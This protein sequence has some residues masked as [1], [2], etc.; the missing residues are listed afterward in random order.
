MREQILKN[1]IFSCLITQVQDGRGGHTAH[2]VSEGTTQSARVGT[3]FQGLA[4][5]CFNKT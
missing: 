5:K 3:P 2:L 4:L 1:L